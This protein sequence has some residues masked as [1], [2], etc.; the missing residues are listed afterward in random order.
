MSS[1]KTPVKVTIGTRGSRLALAQSEIVLAGL[2]RFFPGVSFELKTIRTVGDKRPTET[3]LAKEAVGFFT[4]ELE[5][6][7]FSG[8]IDM[9]VHSL[10][11]LPITLPTGLEIAAVT[12][13]ENPQ[14]VLIT[15]KRTSLKE[16]SQGSRIGTGSPRRKAQLLYV[17]PDLRV[18]PIRGN[19]ETRMQKVASQGLDGVVLASCGLSRCG[20]EGAGLWPIPFALMLPAPGQGALAVEIRSGDE[21]V[22][23][24]AARVDDVDSRFATTAERA[25][26]ASLGGGCQLPLGALATVEGQTLRLEGVLLDPDG[27]RRIRLSTEGPKEK[28]REIGE[29]LGKQLMKQGAE[30]LLYASR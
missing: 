24:L 4:K 23:G 6:A 2:K 30:E 3:P 19:V 15:E 29:L 5:E 22:K 28:A 11:D 1:S 14:D 25:F 10:K 26:H 21:R 17:R 9:A 27:K 18:V 13:R 16:L 8:A 20:L 7:L 12:K